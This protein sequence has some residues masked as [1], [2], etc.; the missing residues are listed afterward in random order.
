MVFG[1]WWCGILGEM[2]LEGNVLRAALLDG[3]LCTF[4]G[5]WLATGCRLRSGFLPCG[6]L[7]LGVR[8]VEVRPLASAGGI[9][10]ACG[11]LGVV[12]TEQAQVFLQGVVTGLLS[13]SVGVLAPSVPGFGE[14]LV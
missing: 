9:E 12:L 4:G 14:L 11:E 7:A 3:G 10:Q 6:V 8:E 13:T 5:A 1:V 2:L